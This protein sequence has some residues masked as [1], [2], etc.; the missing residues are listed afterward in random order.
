[1]RCGVPAV[2]GVGVGVVGVASG[3]E[4][5]DTMWCTLRSVGC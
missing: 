3:V 2:G 1:M 5:K 4:R